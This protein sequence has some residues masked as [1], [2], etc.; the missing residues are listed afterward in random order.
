M[1]SRSAGSRITT[2]FNF[3]YVALTIKALTV[4]DAGVYTCRAYNAKGEATNVCNL[5]VISLKEI[6][7]ETQYEDTVMK[8]QFLEDAAHRTRTD[9]EDTSVTKMPPKFLGP[10]KGTTKIRES[11]NAHFEV[12]LE[13]QNDPTMRVEWYLN[14]K[15]LMDASRIKF[16]NDFG[17]VA[18]DIADVRGTDAGTYTVVARNS[19]GEAQISATMEVECKSSVKV[20][21]E[22]SSM[23][24]RSIF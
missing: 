19:M 17:Y 24:F 21:R 14:G 5:A 22:I 15:A 4:R 18:L 7:T 11:Q 8:M 20:F 10:L 13:P 12:R 3:G 9:F 1:L 2:F 16:Y 23:T 6:E